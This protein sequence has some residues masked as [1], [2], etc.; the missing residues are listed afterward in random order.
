MDRDHSL[1]TQKRQDIVLETFQVYQL[2]FEL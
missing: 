1:R 2:Q